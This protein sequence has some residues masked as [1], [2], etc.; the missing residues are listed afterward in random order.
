MA[1]FTSSGTGSASLERD[2]PATALGIGVPRGTRM[3]G[4]THPDPSVATATIG[5]ACHDG[6][7]GGQERRVASGDGVVR[8]GIDITSKGK[9]G[10]ESGEFFCVEHM[11]VEGGT[12]M[13][14][15][16]VKDRVVVR[17][18]VEGKSFREEH[19]K[20]RVKRLTG[21]FEVTEESEHLC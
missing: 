17:I 10:G 15:G 18:T 9:Q 4:F 12:G 3:G 16:D 1:N 6:C 11:I 5:A 20:G 8:V 2:G 7:G 19:A 14:E 13:D 21:G